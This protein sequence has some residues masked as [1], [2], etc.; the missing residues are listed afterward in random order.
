MNR[1]FKKYTCPGC[2]AE[3]YVGITMELNDLNCGECGNA[4]INESDFG[5]VEIYDGKVERDKKPLRI[6]DTVEEYTD[7]V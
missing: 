2:G 4:T 7:E 1:P 3:H 5:Q 6:Y